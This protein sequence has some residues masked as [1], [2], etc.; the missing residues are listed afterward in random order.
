MSGAGIDG[1][2][3][4]LATIEA[5]EQLYLLAAR[6]SA[7]AATSP[8]VG[9]LCTAHAMLLLLARRAEEA[10]ELEEW[11]RMRALCG[12]I[13]AFIDDPDVE[14]LDAVGLAWRTLFGPQA[15]Q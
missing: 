11:D 2:S 14:R 4:A 5:P 15:L 6:A 12:R 13:G 8:S 1:L 7:L 3:R 10:L 9:A